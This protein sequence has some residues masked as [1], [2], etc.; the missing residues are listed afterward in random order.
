MRAGYVTKAKV[1]DLCPSFIPKYLH[2]E[3]RTWGL[4]QRHR[5]T[6]GLYGALASQVS[7]KPS[8]WGEVLFT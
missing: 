2:T 4:L 8:R 7:H 3:E 5:A 1:L 6:S